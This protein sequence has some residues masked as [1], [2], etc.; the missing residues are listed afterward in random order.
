MQALKIAPDRVEVL[1]RLVH[2][3]CTVGAVCMELRRPL[4]ILSELLRLY[5]KLMASL[6]NTT[7]EQGYSVRTLPQ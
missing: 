4:Q 6:Q 3:G 2:T 7:C 5:G 1:I